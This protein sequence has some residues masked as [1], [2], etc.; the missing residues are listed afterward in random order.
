MN[1]IMLP[2]DSCCAS[3]DPLL[4]NGL[5]HCFSMRVVEGLRRSY[6]QLHRDEQTKLVQ[7][8]HYHVEIC[9]FI[10][11]VLPF[12][13]QLFVSLQLAKHQDRQA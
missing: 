5:C 9:T 7:L 1:D 2:A 3:A 11:K 13:T 4:C 8:Y 10:Q 6:C 12:C